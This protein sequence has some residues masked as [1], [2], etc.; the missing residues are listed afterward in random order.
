[1]TNKK[2]D[3]QPK[4]KKLVLDDL[5]LIRKESLSDCCNTTVSTVK[6]NCSSLYVTYWYECNECKKPCNLKNY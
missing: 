6:N 2:L 3:S 4:P 5:K 1:M